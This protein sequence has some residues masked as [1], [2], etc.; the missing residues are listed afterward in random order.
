MRL[1]DFCIILKEEWMPQAATAQQGGAQLAGGPEWWTAALKQM[2][3]GGP[4]IIG[5]LTRTR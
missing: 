2:A 4:Q 5:Q 1:G 3:G